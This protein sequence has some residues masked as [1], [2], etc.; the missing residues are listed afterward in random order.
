MYV[1][2]YACMYVGTYARTYVYAFF[3]P[4][5]VLGRAL[6]AGGEDL[7]LSARMETDELQRPTPA[8]AQ[9]TVRL[10]CLACLACP[11]VGARAQNR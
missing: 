10:S 8:A 4:V 1:C 9:A 7:K 2:M 5:Q 11:S 3:M 6:G